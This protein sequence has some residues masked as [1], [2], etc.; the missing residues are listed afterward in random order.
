MQRSDGLDYVR[1]CG[2]ILVIWQHACSVLGDERRNLIFGLTVGQIG[3]SLFL[4]ISGYLASHTSRTPADWMFARLRRIYPAYWLVISA[5]LV[6]ALLSGYKAV[7]WRLAIAQ[8]AGVAWFTHGSQIVNVPTWFISLL[9]ACYCLAFLLH[10]LPGAGWIALAGAVLCSALAMSGFEP[11]T[12]THVSTFLIGFGLGKCESERSRAIWLLAA[13][14]YTIVLSIGGSR[15]SPYSGAA[16]AALAIGLSINHVDILSHKLAD[17]SYCIYLVHGPIL[18]ATA[19]VFPKSW[20][21]IIAI[22]LPCSLMAS[23][24]VALAAHRLDHWLWPTFRPFPA[25]VAATPG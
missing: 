5:S 12:I 17:L 2:L 21:A 23:V 6:A 24:V 14:A 22:G 15:W 20:G 16:I 4:V 11:L 7:T 19:K 8:L 1:V 13:M 3:V 18:L 10:M 25:K 9:L